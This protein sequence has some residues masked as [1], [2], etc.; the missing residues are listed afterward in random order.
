MSCFS[1]FVSLFAFWLLVFLL[2]FFILGL[3]FFNFRFVLLF[4]PVFCYQSPF[5]GPLILSL[6]FFFLTHCIKSKEIK[7]NK[8]NVNLCLSHFLICNFILICVIIKLYSP[9][10]FLKFW[11]GK[12][13]WFQIYFKTNPV[14]LKALPHFFFFIKFCSFFTFKICS[15]FFSWCER[16]EKQLTNSFLAARGYKN[17]FTET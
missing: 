12:T 15:L 4:D 7:K 2:I 5:F 17:I 11:E 1:F 6:L 16:Q 10:K 3:L 13:V 9:V 14:I 8:Y